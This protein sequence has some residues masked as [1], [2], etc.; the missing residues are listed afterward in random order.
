MSSFDKSFTDL[1]KRNELLEK[2]L[3]KILK[4]TEK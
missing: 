4:E 2:K 3:D 1:I